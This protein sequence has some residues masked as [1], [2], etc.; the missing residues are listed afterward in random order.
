MLPLSNNRT[1]IY[2]ANEAVSEGGRGECEGV[3]RKNSKRKGKD[4]PALSYCILLF[5]TL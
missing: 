1:Q 4:I 3:Y 2:V 5:L